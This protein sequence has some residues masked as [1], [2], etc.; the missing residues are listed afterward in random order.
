M[1]EERNL[2]LG[3]IFRAS[4]EASRRFGWIRRVEVVN[5]GE[6]ANI[7]ILDGL[8]GIM[9][10][11]ADRSMQTELSTLL[12]AYRMA[13][14]SPEGGIGLF[15]LSSIPIDQPRPNESLRATTVFCIGLDGTT[16]LSAAQIGAFETR[17]EVEAEPIVR[18][19]RS[20]F[21]RR[22]AFQLA[23]KVPQAVAHGGR[24]GT[25]RRGRRRAHGV[26]P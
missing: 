12:D 9:P 14:M 1:F 3:L 22:S 24:R 21:L 25:G 17:G 5:E 19:G 15:R 2:D 4:W 18:G 13:E 11:D 10:A 8:L 26:A 20:A 7:E 16:L 23:T 6:E